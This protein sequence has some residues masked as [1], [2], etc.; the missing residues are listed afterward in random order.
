MLHAAIMEMEKGLRGRLKFS[1][2]AYGSLSTLR[3]ECRLA[4]PALLVRDPDRFQVAMEAIGDSFRPPK[5]DWLESSIEYGIGLGGMRVFADLW[6]LERFSDCACSPAR[7]ARHRRHRIP[8]AQ[9]RAS[10][11]H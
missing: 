11:A 1:D 8:R 4:E 9:S 3:T 2:P 6:N 10:A 5:L 7:A